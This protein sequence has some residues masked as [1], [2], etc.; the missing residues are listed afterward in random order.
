MSESATIVPTRKVESTF[1]A[2]KLDGISL[3]RLEA[4][5]EGLL[6][7]MRAL[8]GAYNQPRMSGDAGEDARELLEGEMERLSDMSDEVA[9]EAEK[10]VPKSRDD[11]DRRARL[12]I[13]W[14]L[15]CGEPW[16]GIAQLAITALEAQ[17]QPQEAVDA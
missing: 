6:A 7:G 5:F 8:E 1:L 15:I 10:R 14:G 13:R 2:G 9:V 3:D 16:S 17:R 4:L 11:A 12:L